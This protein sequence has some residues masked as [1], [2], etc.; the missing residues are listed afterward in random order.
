[1]DRSNLLDDEDENEHGDDERPS[2][3]YM[4]LRSTAQTG[5]KD[6]KEVDIEKMLEHFS[7]DDFMKGMYV[8][9]DS[10]K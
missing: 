6:A 4:E 5:D 3:L 1:M 2:Y 10:F 9:N 8:K 7:F